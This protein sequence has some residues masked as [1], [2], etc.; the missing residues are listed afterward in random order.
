MLIDDADQSST[1]TP[2]SRVHSTSIPSELIFAVATSELVG[3]LDFCS[4]EYWIQSYE[5]REKGGSYKSYK[6]AHD[7]KTILQAHIHDGMHIYTTRR[8]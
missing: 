6:F 3:E 5:H 4:F 7:L 1:S 8:V 2:K